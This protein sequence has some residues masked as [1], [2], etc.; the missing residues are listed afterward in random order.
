MNN[1]KPIFELICI[2]YSLLGTGIETYV[3]IAMKYMPD[4]LRGGQPG[5]IFIGTALL[6]VFIGIITFIVNISRKIYWLWWCRLIAIFVSFILFTF[7][8]LRV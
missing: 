1:K 8:S 7:I 6:A 5:G 2:S 3:L 4:F